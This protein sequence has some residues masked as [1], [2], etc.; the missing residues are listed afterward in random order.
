MIDL[1]RV[2]VALCT[3]H[4]QL[5]ALIGTDFRATWNT[6]CNSLY[7]DD[8]ASVGDKFNEGI[9]S[10]VL[11]ELWQKVLE[12]SQGMIEYDVWQDIFSC[13]EEDEFDGDGNVIKWK[14]ENEQATIT[15][16]NGFSIETLVDPE[17]GEFIETNTL[18]ALYLV[19]VMCDLMFDRESIQDDLNY[20][21]LWQRMQWEEGLRQDV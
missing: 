5:R 8:R 6:Y 17:E 7:P 4:D 10:P 20:R 19:K 15:S 1:A 2:E 9:L 14:F 12:D 16:F 11:D 3:T 13:W 21:V 18:R